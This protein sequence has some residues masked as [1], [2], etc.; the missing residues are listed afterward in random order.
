MRVPDGFTPGPVWAPW[1]GHGDVNLG[2]RRL[3]APLHEPLTFVV[4]ADTHLSQAETY[5]GS[6]DL[7]TAAFA[8]TALESTAGV[9][10]DPRRHHAG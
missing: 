10:H 4:A 5:N 8:A 6:D 7:A 3:P 9:L 1:T 2:L